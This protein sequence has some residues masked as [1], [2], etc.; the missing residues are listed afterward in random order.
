MVRLVE[1]KIRTEIWREV[2]LDEQWLLK[3]YTEYMF[4]KKSHYDLRC[5]TT[6]IL[7]INPSEEQDFLAHKDDF[8]FAGLL[9]TIIEREKK[10]HSFSQ[11]NLEPGKGE[12]PSILPYFLLLPCSNR[13]LRRMMGI[14]CLLCGT[15]KS[16]KI[17]NPHVN[18]CIN[19]SINQK[20][21]K[22]NPLR[23]TLNV[24]ILPMLCIIKQFHLEI[25]HSL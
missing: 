15:Q 10:Y 5:T 23:P 7:P 24:L 6:Q 3:E 4:R 1:K 14:Y 11:H 21:N 20:T 8:L 22:Q 16:I 2:A 17:K 12:L 13:L 9:Y 19:F 18:N 25:W